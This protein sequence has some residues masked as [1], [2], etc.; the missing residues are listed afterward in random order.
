VQ[1]R[2]NQARPIHVFAG[3]YFSAVLFL[4]FVIFSGIFF[5]HN[6]RK[7]EKIFLTLDGHVF[8]VEI[9]DTAKKIAMGLSGH[10]PLSSDQGMF[11]IFD[12]PDNYGFWMKDMLFS[13][14]IIWFDSEMKIV[15]IERNLSPETYPAI[16]YP[17][18]PSKYVLE[19]PAGIS[20]KYGFKIGDYAKFSEI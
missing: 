17:D 15:H 19:I 4:L 5:I 3:K 9:A 11:F 12:Q 7:T 16:Y 1:P 13:L 2:E 14:D 10:Q 6:Q 18:R 8:S 20:D